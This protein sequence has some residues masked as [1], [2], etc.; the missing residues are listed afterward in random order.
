MKKLLAGSILALS[1]SFSFA[2]GGDLYATK[3]SYIDHLSFRAMAGLAANSKVVHTSACKNRVESTTHVN[4][5]EQYTSSVEK[6]SDF[7]N[8]GLSFAGSFSIGLFEWELS[9]RFRTEVAFWAFSDFTQNL[10]NLNRDVA[11]SSTTN[12]A[13]NNWDINSNKTINQDYASTADRNAVLGRFGLELALATND[14]SVLASL[15]LHDAVV[16]VLNSKYLNQVTTANTASST[17]LPGTQSN[18]KWKNHLGVNGSVYLTP[19]KC[20]DNA[21]SIGVGVTGGCSRGKGAKTTLNII[22]STGHLTESIAVK[23]RFTSC[24]GMLGFAVTTS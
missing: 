5:C 8:N 15:G 11:A 17:S 7:D 19:F 9:Q 21:C 18:K 24:E 10:T 1:A 16:S 3:G 22:N 23:D 13:P 6:G 20:K 14:G 12:S 2:G 4:S